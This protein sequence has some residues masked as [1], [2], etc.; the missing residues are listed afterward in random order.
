LG[1]LRIYKE[2][3]SKWDTDGRNRAQMLVPS[4]ALAAMAGLLSSDVGIVSGYHFQIRRSGEVKESEDNP[5]VG[6]LLGIRARKKRRV[7]G[8]H[9]CGS[10]AH[11]E[12]GTE[13][14]REGLGLGQVEVG[15]EVLT[16]GPIELWWLIVRDRR[17]GHLLCSV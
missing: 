6:F 15:V 14:E 12:L 17:G 16:V 3:G 9:G 7:R 8:I 4:S 11:G 5:F 1:S 2:R 10:G 13:R